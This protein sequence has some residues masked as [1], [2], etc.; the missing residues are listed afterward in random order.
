MKV[1]FLGAHNT[2]SANTRMSGILVD[3]CLALDAGA[4]T[5]GLSLAQQLG[6]KAVVLSHHHYDHIRDIPALGMNLFLNQASVD[7]YGTASVG[8]AIGEH[9]LN[10]KLYPDL[11]HRPP[12]APT[13]H[14]HPLELFSPEDIAGYEITLLPMSHSVPAAGIKLVSPEGKVLFYTGDSGPGLQACWQQVAPDVLIVEVTAPNSYE[15]FAYDSGHLTPALLESEL[16]MLYEMHGYLPS[17]FT[18][19]MNPSLEAEI[20]AEIESV[21]TSL[22]SSITLA[23]EDMEVDI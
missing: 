7:I 11:F 1:R 13:L 15:S 10:N 23:R 18:V 22:S 21:A 8:E 9:L 2:E 16:S 14:F 3:E 6:L 19:H 12:E 17:I 20:A 5:S 4:L